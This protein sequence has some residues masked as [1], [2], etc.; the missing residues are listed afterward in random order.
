MLG[1]QKKLHI[2]GELEEQIKLSFN[3]KK[4]MLSLNV[5]QWMKKTVFKQIQMR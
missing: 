1:L 3:F 4:I 5:L 2:H